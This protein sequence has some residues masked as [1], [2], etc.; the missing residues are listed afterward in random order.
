MKDGEAKEVAFVTVLAFKCVKKLV[1]SWATR[2]WQHT[3]ACRKGNQP[4]FA[5]ITITFDWEGTINRLPCDHIVSVTW[6]K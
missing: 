2:N 1:G 4:Y 5:H 6:Q 3:R